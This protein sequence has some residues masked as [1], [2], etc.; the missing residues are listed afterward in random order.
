ML[1]K[2]F[3]LLVSVAA[4]GLSMLCTSKVNAAF[5]EVKRIWGADRYE[6]CSKIVQEGWKSTSEYAV[7]VNGE[8]FPDALSSSVLAKKYNAPILLAKGSTLGDKTYNELKRLKVQHVFIV[9]GTAV[10]TPSVES[11]MKSMG[12]TTERLSGQDRN[13]TSASVAEK[14]GTD[15]GVILTTDNDFTDALS[16]APMAARYQMPIILMPK[17]G[18]PGS[19][20]KFMAGKNISKAYIIG[21]ADV[22]S[23]DTALKFPNVERIDGNNK[24][25]RNINIIKAFGDK[26]NFSNVCMAYS[27][28][29]ADALSGSVFAAQGANPI[30][31]MG[32]KSSEYTKYFL[33]TK[34]SEIKN[35]TVFGGTSGIKELHEQDVFNGTSGDNSNDISNTSDYLENNGSIAVKQGDWIYYSGSNGASSATGNFFKEKNDGSGKVKLSDD[36]AQKI[37]IQG[38]YIYY[39]SYHGQ[40]QKSSFYKMK[41]DGTERGQLTTDIP[42]CVNFQGDYIYYIKYDN[43]SVDNLKICKIKKDGTGKQAIGNERGMYLSVKDDWLYYADLD[44]GSKIY[45][46]RTDGSDKQLLCGDSA[47]NYMNVVGDWIYYCNSDENNNLYRVKIDGSGKQKLNN[48]NSRNINIVG[49]YIYYSAMDEND[50]GSLYKMKVDGSQNKIL[51]NMDCSTAV[52][53][54]DDYIYCTGFNS[55]GIYRIKND[56]T[57]YELISKNAY[58][59]SLYVTGN[60]VYYIEFMSGDINSRLYRM[61]LDGTSNETIQ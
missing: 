20:E 1:K 8:N 47:L 14:I 52:A 28:Q 15:N 6:T 46:M 3:C 2:K 13:E 54:H 50:N 58:V 29:F 38:D 21:G 39:I 16:I 26:V 18:I 10:I 19:V 42:T 41:N 36:I 40:N 25:E 37:W 32:D 4:V 24:Y 45:K 61:N 43:T 7:I 31:L 23:E 12:I 17:D 44:D 53:V 56:G 55:K 35:I 9:G 11:T 48:S 30:I 51:S 49:S 34:E 60:Y 22:I 59:I 33:T 57:G 27:E 5:P